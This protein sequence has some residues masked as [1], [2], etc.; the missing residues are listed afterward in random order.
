[1]GLRSYSNERASDGRENNYVYACSVIFTTYYEVK[2][3]R[4]YQLIFVWVLPLFGAITVILI[5]REN[6]MV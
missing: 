2:E 3:R 4:F 5:N 1:L 6:R